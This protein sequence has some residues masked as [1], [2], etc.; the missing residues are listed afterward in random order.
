MTLGQMYKINFA[1]PNVMDYYAAMDV[2]KEK[3][4]TTNELTNEEKSLIIPCG[5]GHMSDGDI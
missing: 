1:L 4:V 5:Y 3:I 2:L